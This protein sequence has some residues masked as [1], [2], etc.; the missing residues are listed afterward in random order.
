MRAASKKAR[1]RE[2]YVS[3][4]ETVSCHI[5]ALSHEIKVEIH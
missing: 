1:E 4:S 3:R 5:I 2:K